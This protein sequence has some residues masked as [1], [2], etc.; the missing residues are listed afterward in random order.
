MAAA[1]RGRMRVI[2][3]YSD[4]PSTRLGRFR[5]CLGSE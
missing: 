4:V 2:E 5:G 1:A 3:L